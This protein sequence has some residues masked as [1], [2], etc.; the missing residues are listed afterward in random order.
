MPVQHGRERRH[1]TSHRRDAPSRSQR[2]QRFRVRSVTDLVLPPSILLALW[3]PVPS[4][5]GAAVVEGADGAHTPGRSDSG[6]L[7][8]GSPHPRKALAAPEPRTTSRS[9]D[10]APVR[11]AIW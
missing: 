5:R 6:R 4:S 2:S 9:W 10:A 3:L 1:L 7:A 11:R 8:A